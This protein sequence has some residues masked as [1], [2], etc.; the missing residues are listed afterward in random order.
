MMRGLTA[1]LLLVGAAAAPATAHTPAGVAGGTPVARAASPA[2][3]IAARQRYFGR[4]NVD[5][6]TGAVRRDRLILS[7]VGVTNFAM[8]IGGHV[9]LLD[10]WVPRGASSGYVPSSPEELAAL[11]PRYVF[12]GHAHFDHAADAVPIAQASGAVLVGSAEHCEEL[13]GR[14][15]SLPPRCISA[16]PAAVAPGTIKRTRLLPGVRTKIVK[17]LHSGPTAPGGYHVPVTPLPSTTSLEH[18]PTPQD[19]AHL[20]EHAPDAEAGSVMYRFRVGDLSL[21][22]HDS[23]G[24]LVDR[25]P[26]AIGALK[27]LRPVDVHLGAIQG[28]NQIGNG[29]R[30]PFT[31]IEALRPGLFVPTH[32]DDW[33]VGI[34]TR[35]EAYREPFER[36]YARLP[37][38]ARPRV[39]FI[40][41]PGDYVQPRVLTFR[42]RTPGR[43]AGR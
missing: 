38:E 43:R 40:T 33:A 11:D 21:V 20:V 28:F 41:D 35:G 13:R 31:Y 23:S 30:D 37:A 26:E 42:V 19:M 16:L 6:R 27:R 24:P 3:T 18:P 17:N 34:T 12:I 5:P 32:H 14:A 36:E 10:A 22:W 39:R 1:A 15:P 25:A 29:M 2:D 4:R 8:A 9:V 7:W